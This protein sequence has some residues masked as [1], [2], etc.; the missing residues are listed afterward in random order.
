[1]VK[2]EARIEL[3]GWLNDVKDFE[4]GRALKVSVDVRKQNHQGEW[5][6]VD[7]TIYDVTTDSR[8]ALDGVKQVVV[9]GRI[10]GT[11]VFQKRDGTSGFTI[12]VR[13][14]AVSP[15]ANQFVSEKVDHAAVNAVWPT[16]TPGGIS[17]EAPF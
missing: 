9:T 10:T 17:E 7:K 14:D 15:A 4:W 12:K 2:N 5:E 6:T 11:N 13:A 3:T 8:A 16:V 1:M